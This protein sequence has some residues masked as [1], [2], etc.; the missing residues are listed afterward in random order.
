MLEDVLAFNVWTR[1]WLNMPTPLGPPRV[2]EAW[3]LWG[4]GCIDLVGTTES[5]VLVVGLSGWMLAA[6]GSMQRAGPWRYGAG[7]RGRKSHI[8]R[9]QSGPG[10]C[11]SEQGRKYLLAI[12]REG[13]APLSLKVSGTDVAADEGSTCLDDT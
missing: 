11:Y 8:R 6:C 12:G 13:K 4:A 10:G 7:G 9:E 3:L 5:R 2:G 1:V